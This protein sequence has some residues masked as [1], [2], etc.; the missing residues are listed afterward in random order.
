MENT[1][2][3]NSEQYRAFGKRHNI[4]TGLLLLL[5]ALLW[6]AG[7]GPGKFLNCVE[8][9]VGS[10]SAIVPTPI[11]APA[12][13]NAV[14]VA[15]PAPP[16]ADANA[17]AAPPS[18]EQIA[19][20]NAITKKASEKPTASLTPSAPESRSAEPGKALTLVLNTRVYFP[21]DKFRLPNDAPDKFAKIVAH[22]KANPT[23]RVQISGYHDRA[24]RLS[25]NAELASKRA[26]AVA[27]ALESAGVAATQIQLQK[28][29]QTRGSGKPEEARRVE[30]I[31]TN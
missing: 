29:S 27:N 10:S 6:L 31:V 7:Y 12:A 1:F 11:P 15:D 17:S 18:A 2:G 5:L 26:S 9:S 25:Y 4:V 23:A 13:N 19:A 24:G 22:L 14:N 8:E 3:L 20:S 21:R 28:P 30:L 16:Q